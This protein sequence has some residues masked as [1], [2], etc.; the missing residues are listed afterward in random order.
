[1]S[2]TDGGRQVVVV[3]HFASCRKRSTSTPS[4]RGG[5]Y[6]PPVKPSEPPLPSSPGPQVARPLE[7]PTAAI[8]LIGEELL[9][10]KVDDENARFLVK[11]LRTLG[12]VTRRIEVVPDEPDEIVTAVRALS[13][14]FTHVF[15]SGGVGA[16]HDDVTMPAVARAFDMPLA[17]RQELA[18]LIERSL[19]AAF[20]ERDLRMADLPEGARLHYGPSDAHATWPVVVVNNVF[21]LPGVPAILQ[22]KFALIADSLRTTP[23]YAHALYVNETE[24]QIAHHLDA[25]VEA[26][27]EVSIGSYPHIHAVDYMVK[28]TL[29]SRSETKLGAALEAL[30]QRLGT[31]V[32]RHE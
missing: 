12:V 8:L 11:A 18:E 27:P 14:R 17:R 25:V 24:G 23:I 7:G 10:G 21:V 6:P 4:P 22:R 29:D 30:R 3:S 28:I 2:S 20:T 1:M 19:G 15:T 31:A 26:H 32:V 13:A 9:S 5:W 16:T